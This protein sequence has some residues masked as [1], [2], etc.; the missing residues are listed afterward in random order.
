[1]TDERVSHVIARLDAALNRL[2][3][4]AEP[5]AASIESAPADLVRRHAQLRA[6]TKEAVEAL[7]RLIGRG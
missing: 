2:Q 3:R 1:V 5:G 7:D 6:R 4:A